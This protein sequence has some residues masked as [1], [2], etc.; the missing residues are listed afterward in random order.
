MST[1]ERGT[2][3]ISDQQKTFTGIMQLT[4]W[5]SV[6][7]GLSTLYLTM[8]FAS[9][10]NWFTSLLIVFGLSILIGLGLKKGSSW[11]VTMAV[12]TGIITIIGLATSMIASFI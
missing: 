6:L 9:G 12:L 5:S 7:I 1:Y 2:Q 4:L 11:Y 10:L 8:V 3:D